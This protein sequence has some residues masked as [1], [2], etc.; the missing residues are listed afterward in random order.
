[1][2]I[3]S[4]HKLLSDIRWYF[5]ITIS[6]TAFLQ[7]GLLGSFGLVF[8][9]VLILYGLCF[10]FF[11][12]KKHSLVRSIP[13]YLVIAFYLYYLLCS[14]ITGN[15]TRYAASII[16]LLLISVISFFQR[17]NE[18]HIDDL[19]ILGKIVAVF[20]LVMAISS[21][22]VSVFFVYFHDVVVKLPFSIQFLMSDVAG[23]F[24]QRMSGFTSNA[25]TT[26]SYCTIS[27]ILSVFAISLPNTNRK[28]KIIHLV[29]II[30]TVVTSTFIVT[31]RTQTLAFASFLV[32]YCFIY[33]LF[34]NK[35]NPK[36]KMTFRIILLVCLILLVLFIGLLSFSNNIREYFLNHVL[37]IT[38]LKTMTGRI[39]V[40]KNAIALSLRNPIFGYN[41]HDLAEAT[42]L[43]ITQAHNVFLEALS[44]SG[45]LGLVL[46]TLYFIITIRSAVKNL[47]MSK[48]LS[49][50]ESVMVCFLFCYLVYFFIFGL[51]EPADIDTSRLTSVC[52]SI[53]FGFIHV[54][55]NNITTKS[56]IDIHS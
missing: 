46:F 20:S 15:Y 45:V 1:M 4:L 56:K 35:T 9:G 14:F 31:S 19:L 12:L 22:C 6:I 37:R 44:F 47:F 13:F 32:S 29:N 36:M 40:Y 50:E 17:S 48:F 10:L 49:Y 54:T 27:S 53:L 5:I 28:W 34:I 3:F 11:N 30:V 39:G 7:F 26:A 21:I 52:Y 51:F 55:Y 25:N 42:Q 38:S 2:N 23:A 24:P 33:F 43:Q 8:Y 16:L 41:Y 18:I